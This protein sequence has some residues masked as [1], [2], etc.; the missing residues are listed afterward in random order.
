MGEALDLV[1]MV[2]VAVCAI[3]RHSTLERRD[4][5]GGKFGCPVIERFQGDLKCQYI[6]LPRP[7]GR[8]LS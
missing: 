6:S 8:W 5:W 2:M 4:N 3:T 7:A 1:V